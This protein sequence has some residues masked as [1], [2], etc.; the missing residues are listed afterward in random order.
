MTG[1]VVKPLAT[2]AS[3]R[4]ISLR[5]TTSCAQ[6]AV[7][8]GGR[9]L[10][11]PL[12]AGGRFARTIKLTPVELSAK[13]LY[14]RAQTKVRRGRSRNLIRTFTVTRGVAAR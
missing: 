10:T 5:I 6:A 9:T 14:V 11:F 2:K 4:R 12:I 1:Q 8:T 3:D 7:A 13:A